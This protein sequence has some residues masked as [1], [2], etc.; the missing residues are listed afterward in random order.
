MASVILLVAVAVC[1]CL[2]NP[3]EVSMSPQQQQHAISLL[4]DAYSAFNRNDISAAVHALDLNIDWQEPAEFPGGG[5]YHGRAEV[6]RYL[7]N[8]RAGWAEGSSEPVRFIVHGDRVVVYVHA[9]FRTKD[10][11]AWTEVCLADVYT[12]RNGTPVAM[13]AFADR[14]A[15]LE[16]VGVPELD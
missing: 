15:A 5:S 4:R 11:S 16:W 14:N 10:S 3:Y 13:R 6:A 1:G 2:T 7:A 8:S 12:F 9:R